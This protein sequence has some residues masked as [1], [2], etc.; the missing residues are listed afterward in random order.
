MSWYQ[1]AM[2]DVDFCDKHRGAV[3]RLRSGG[4]RMGEPYS[5]KGYNL[6]WQRLTEGIETS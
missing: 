4:F 3:I 5:L 6:L 1:Q 2:K